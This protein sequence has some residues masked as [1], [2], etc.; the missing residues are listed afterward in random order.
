MDRGSR[1]GE[2]LQESE[3]KKGYMYLL[4]P[5]GVA[6]EGKINGRISREKDGRIRAPT[7]ELDE[8]G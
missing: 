6:A 4:T 3:N 8:Q 5:N 1:K 2:K 7:W